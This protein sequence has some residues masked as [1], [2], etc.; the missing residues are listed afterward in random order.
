MLATSCV[1]VHPY[2]SIRLP[3]DWHFSIFRKYA[4]KIRFY[5][6]LTSVTDNFILT[7]PFVL[8]QS[9]RILQYLSCFAT[10]F[11]TRNHCEAL[12]YTNSKDISLFFWRN[13]PQWARASSFEPTISAG[14]RPQ[15]HAL[16]RA[17]AGFGWK[18]ST[19]YRT[20]TCILDCVCCSFIAM[21]LCKYCRFM[22]SAVLVRCC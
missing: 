22:F 16:D 15:T 6:N 11:G 9:N 10:C 12:I 20:V 7:D 5:W 2:G 8:L 1:P 21:C 19:R 3:L 18:I 4:E 13:S 17:V 14:E